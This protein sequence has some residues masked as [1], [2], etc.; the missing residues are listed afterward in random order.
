[1]LCNIYGEPSNTHKGE[2]NSHK[3]ISKLSAHI[4]DNNILNLEYPKILN[5]MC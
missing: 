5:L 2:D 1:M 3:I 4:I